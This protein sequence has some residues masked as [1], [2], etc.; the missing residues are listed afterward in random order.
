M[1]AHRLRR[2]WDSPSKNAGVGCHCLLQCVKVKAW[3]IMLQS[4]S[5][6]RQ[7]LRFRCTVAKQKVL[8]AQS[9]PT[10][11]DLMDCSPPGSSVHGILQARTLEWVVI[12]FFR[13]SSWLG[14]EPR[15]PALPADFFFYHLSHQV[16]ERAIYS[17][18]L[19]WAARVLLVGVGNDIRQGSPSFPFKN[20]AAY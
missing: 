14:I 5:P 2:P 11:C 17:L 12:P 7:C 9:C 10:L 20:R 15:S 13:W 6:H 1:A 18:V 3:E 8:V 16:P 19:I 4:E